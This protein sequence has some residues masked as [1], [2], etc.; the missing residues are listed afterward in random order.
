M[1]WDE[2]RVSRRTLLLGGLGVVVAAAAGGVAAGGVAA[3]WD[4]PRFVRLRGGCGD[5]PAIPRSS[6]DVVTGSFDSRAMNASV[7]WVVALPP[8][9]R[10][11]DGTP[12]V[13]CL[14][15][16]NDGPE[17]MVSG[18]GLPGFATAAGQRVVFAAP[19][20]GDSLY[21]H[22][23]ADGRDPLGWALDEFLPMVEKRYGVGGSRHRRAALG[24]SMGAAGALL[25]AQ[26]R[27]D[28]VNAVVALSPAVFPSYAAARSGHDYTFDSA[29][30]WQRYGVWDRLDE[31][32]ATPT[33][34]ACGDADP[35][36]PTARDLLH[37]IPGATGGIGGGCHDE[38]FW[39]RQA[40]PSLRFCS[41]NL[42]GL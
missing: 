32:A 12:V 21:W 31:L 23:R 37:R 8:G 14:T 20:G 29:Q 38:G 17:V 2:G 41:R 7:P 6:Y 5:T 25:V 40:T 10:P 13:L 18:V 15:G 27:P 3:E 28:L 4:D 42:S 35:F 11:G 30:D 33:Y 26:Q 16:R 36:A 9:H 19:G 34:V 1:K 22:P 39:R 24:W